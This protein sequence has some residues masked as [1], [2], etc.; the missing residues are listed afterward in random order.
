MNAATRTGSHHGDHT[1]RGGGAATSSVRVGERASSGRPNGGKRG[2]GG[3][4]ATNASGGA[5]GNANASNGFSPLHDK[6][7][8]DGSEPLGAADEQQED[9]GEGAVSHATA[10]DVGAP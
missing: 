5:V 2:G 7:E 4:N 10:L 8:A 3:S 6:A 9:P 1:H